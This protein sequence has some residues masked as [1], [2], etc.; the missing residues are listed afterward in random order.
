MDFA[1]DDD[2]QAIV[3]SVRTI[4]TKQSGTARAHVVGRQGHDD[5]LLD[6]L[7]REGYLDM[8]SE[9]STG[10]LGAE[11][12]AEEASRHA[13]CANVALRLLVAPALLGDGSAPR[14]AVT[15]S[16]S[17]GPVRYGQHAELLLVLDGDEV[18]VA[19]IDEAKP[20]ASSFGFPFAGITWTAERRLG[21][22]SGAT[23]RNWWRVAIAAEIVGALDGAIQHTIEYLSHRKQF[24]KPLATRQALQH[25]LAEAHVRA[26]GA[27]WLARFAAYSGADDAH[28]ATAAAYA[29][30]VAQLVGT[31]LH[32][33]SG[34]IGFT[35]EFDLQLW[36]TRLHALRVELGGATAHQLA[37]ADAYWG[38]LASSSGGG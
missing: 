32:Q 9:A 36:T 35:D 28:A 6:T 29:T 37:T 7:A 5:E 33:M 21:P 8:W 10:G 16:E 3:D 13:A 38:G 11:L 20:V 18:V 26:E 23:L 19:R 1:L 15:R 30:Q 2:Q 27:R 17:R 4:L 25:R 22:P 12:V 34:A 24:G 14:I 31:D